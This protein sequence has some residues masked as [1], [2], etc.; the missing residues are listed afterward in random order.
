MTG[1]T[2]VIGHRGT[3]K[4]SFL[5]RLE[6]YFKKCPKLEGRFLDLDHEIA[7]RQNRPVAR[8]FEQ[9]GESYFRKLEEETFR[10]LHAEARLT[11]A[12]F[13]LSVGGGFQAEIP[14]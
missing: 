14:T 5:R 3:G 10:S 7:L 4:S 8:I 12:H 13:F 9:E 11:G 2:L 6:G 1:L